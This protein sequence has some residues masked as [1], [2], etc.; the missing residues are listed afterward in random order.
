[1]PVQF[2]FMENDM[3]HRMVLFHNRA[4]M[5]LSSVYR[6]FLYSVG[7][8]DR[9]GDENVFQQLRDKFADRLKYQLQSVAREVLDQSTDRAS[10]G[11]LNHMF[12]RF[13]DDYRREFIQ[14]VRA[15]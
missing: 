9:Q 2:S 12:S 7:S 15:L 3:E 5:I 11:T 13:I 10:A 6:S 14:K 1:M 8:I 4:K